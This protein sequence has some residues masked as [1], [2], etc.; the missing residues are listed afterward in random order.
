MRYGRTSKRPDRTTEPHS[1]IP[2]AIYFDVLPFLTGYETKLWL[3]LKSREWRKDGTR[4]GLVKKS[5][6]RIAKDIRMSRTTTQRAF[7]G[8]RK[9]GV[10]EW[11]GFGIRLLEPSFT[12][13]VTTGFTTEEHRRRRPRNGPGVAHRWAGSGVIPRPATT[14]IPFSP[15]ES[16]CGRSVITIRRA[17]DEPTHAVDVRSVSVNHASRK[18]AR[19]SARSSRALPD[20]SHSSGKDKTE[21]SDETNSSA[22]LDARP[23]DRETMHAL[24]RKI[25]A[26]AEAAAEEGA[27]KRD[28]GIAAERKKDADRRAKLKRQAEE[29]LAAEKGETP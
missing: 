13:A 26:R 15:N 18:S 10:A 17:R 21:V 28:A 27:A 20:N 6:N 1:R 22:E 29:L 5:L 9:K 2:D 23:L 19:A 12:T 11:A 14:V 25:R 8:L 4:R 3:A 24:M 16:G 7:S